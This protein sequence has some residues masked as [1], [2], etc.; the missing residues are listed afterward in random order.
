[1]A[2][3]TTARLITAAFTI[4]GS[5][6]V[7]RPQSFRATMPRYLPAPRALIIISG[8]AEL[9]CAVGLWNPRTRSLAG[10]GSVALLLAV[11]PANIELARK[12]LTRGTTVQKVIAVLRVPLQIPLIVSMWRTARMASPGRG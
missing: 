4:S 12:L 3:T 7:I 10:Y 6:H 9:L 8:V 11:W 1:M 2:L 5:L